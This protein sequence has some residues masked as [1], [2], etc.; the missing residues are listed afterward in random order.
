MTLDPRALY[1]L[2]N[3]IPIAPEPIIDRF[4]GRNLGIIASLELHIK[5][6]NFVSPIVLGLQPVAKINLSDSI[7]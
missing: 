4:F 2:A 7:N 3:S 5:S 6:E 1:I